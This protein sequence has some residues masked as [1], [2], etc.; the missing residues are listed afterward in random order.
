VGGKTPRCSCS[1]VGG[2]GLVKKESN[3]GA[4]LGFFWGWEIPTTIPM[5]GKGKRG[6]SYCGRRKKRRTVSE[7][8]VGRVEE[9]YT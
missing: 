1:V 4:R 7:Y 3:S 6:K 8:Y 9:A 2:L 5:V